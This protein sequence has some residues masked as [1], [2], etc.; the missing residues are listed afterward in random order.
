MENRLVFSAKALAK[1]EPP[2]RGRVYY[3][4]AGCSGLALCVTCHDT[5][6]YYR[7]GRIDGEFKRIPVGRFDKITV[8]NAR[9]AV[10]R[11]NGEVAVGV[12]PVQT[13]KTLGQYH[14]WYMDHHS[15][16][17]KRTW[18][19][20]ESHFKLHLKHWENRR[21][22]S[23]KRTEVQALHTKIANEVGRGA[24]D[25]MLYLLR[26]MYAKA[27]ADGWTDKNPAAGVRR[28]GRNERERFLGADEL[29][30]FFDAVRQLKRETTRDFFLV[31]LFTGARRQNVLSMRWDELILDRQ[32]WLIPGA[33]FKNKKPQAVTLSP[34]AMEILL[35]RLAKRDAECPWVFPG[36]SRPGHLNDPKAAWRS[37]ID[38]SKLENL[39]LHDL[40]R[41]L[42]SWQA[43]TGASLAVIGKSL[44]HRTSSA[45]Q[46][47]ARLD[48]D[49]VRAAVN[50]A[51][52]AISE[53]ASKKSEPEKK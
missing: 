52:A 45:T 25:N 49:P 2:A 36:Q 14:R 16:P 46:I 15:K 47:Y 53:A 12:N 51:T 6:T 20:D 11:I 40:R 44:G 7:C 35:R 22:G 33:K 37:I 21:L 38:K 48:I 5:R 13:R 30:R 50:K 41:T 34:E 39:R 26:H 4:D 3:Y 32:L 42:G 28:Y 23:I 10:A 27:N 29:P 24:A 18:A 1:I 43:G 19:R 17:H 8:E 9:K 31:A